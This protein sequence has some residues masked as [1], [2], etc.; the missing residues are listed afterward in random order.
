M[1]PSSP[2]RAK[3]PNDTNICGICYDPIQLTHSPLKA[4]EPPNTS[5]ILPFGLSLSCPSAHTYCSHCLTTYIRG[6]IDPNKDGRGS[7]DAIVFPIM[8]P[9]C[10]AAEWPGGIGEDIAN[11]ILGGRDMDLWVSPDL[12]SITEVSANAGVCS[13]N[14]SSTMI[15]RR[16]SVPTRSVPRYCRNRKTLV[17]RMQSVR[18][19]IVSC[20][21]LAVQHGTE[22]CPTLSC[23]HQP[24]H[25][26]HL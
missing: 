11:R 8:C 6:R 10:T 3:P 26:F 17:F 23:I 22:V 18:R 5:A 14:R 4:S 24:A 7:S 13:I 20:V 12:V 9:Q 25:F 16:C 19:V 1:L 15:C 21:S 2:K